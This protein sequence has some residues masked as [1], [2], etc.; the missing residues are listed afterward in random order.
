MDRSS[1]IVSTAISGTTPS[2][3]DMQPTPLILAP[4]MLSINHN[5]SLYIQFECQ[6][7]TGESA[8]DVQIVQPPQQ[9]LVT[10]ALMR[11]ENKYPTRKTTNLNRGGGQ[12]V[13]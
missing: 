5:M 1:L 4:S 8:D 2:Q 13:Q 7:K 11:K 6:E 3:T 12:T 9:C 10:E